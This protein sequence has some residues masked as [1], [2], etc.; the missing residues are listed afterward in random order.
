MARER[1]AAVSKPQ[2]QVASGG[3]D[4]AGSADLWGYSQVLGLKGKIEDRVTRNVARE[5]SLGGNHE[6]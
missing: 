1:Q 6:R 5:L 3:S 2:P 4:R